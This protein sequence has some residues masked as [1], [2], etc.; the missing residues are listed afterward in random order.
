MIR[1]AVIL[2]AVLFSAS[3][4]AWA[5]DYSKFYQAAPAGSVA[6]FPSAIPA[7]VAPS[8][9]NLQDDTLRMWERGYAPIG[10]SSFNG[11]LRD[12][13]K[14]LKFAKKLKARYVVTAAGQV[15][16][17]SGAVPMTLPSLNTAQTFGTVSATN[18]YGGNATGTF[19]AT[20]TTD[21]SQT[22][23]IPFAIRRADQVAAFFQPVER[24]GSGVYG[25]DLTAEE[26][27]ALG[28]NHA[29]YVLAVR[30][31]SPAFDADMLPGDIILSINGDR[32]TI[33][34]WNAAMRSPTGT[35]VK[36]GLKRGGEI[37]TL[38]VT[39]PAGWN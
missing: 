26:R 2:P 36:V 38:N 10:Y 21:G 32:L 15:S 27:A 35:R 13:T 17:T 29:L 1:T 3:Q 18:S 19:N 4:P 37:K 12:P 9:G 7:E 22:T 14:A 24:K 33:E 39:I 34:S 16:E 5:D 8:S 20:T 25:R 11:Q 31:G 23:Y 30:E 28:T 6:L